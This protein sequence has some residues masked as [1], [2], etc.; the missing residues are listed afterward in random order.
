MQTRITGSAN[1]IYVL[2][3]N[4]LKKV[5]NGNEVISVQNQY[6]ELANK[7]N[8]DE[9]K[10]TTKYNLNPGTLQRNMLF[11]SK[12]LVELNKGNRGL[13]FSAS[14]LDRLSLFVNGKK[15]DDHYGKFEGVL[16]KIKEGIETAKNHS[17]DFFNDLRELGITGTVNKLSSSRFEP[18]QCME[19]TK[20]SLWFMGILGTKWI[21]N[22]DEFKS[23]LRELQ[24]RPQASV[25]FLMIDPECP[26]FELLK[27]IRKENIKDTSSAIFKELIQEFPCLEAR[28]YSSF[29]NFRIV[30]IDN[31]LLALSRYQQNE[32]K[33]LKSNMGWEAPHMIIESEVGEW[34]LYDP[35][36]SY[37]N[38]V[39]E[40][41]K[42]L[43]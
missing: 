8:E 1:D 30:I 21:K 29:P 35:F 27:I 36:V 20:H 15:Y 24:S 38:N 4:A 5:T 18:R 12:K 10:G 28:Y 32:N 33:Y 26:N 7:L 37:Y 14:Y 34:S 43:K 25:R 6:E 17:A 22:L 40:Q 11:N 41:A 16:F 9:F 13:T 39:W 23:F 19:E 3:Q 42:I 31:K 2:I